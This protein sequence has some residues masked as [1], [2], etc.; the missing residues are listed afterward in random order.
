MDHPA[1]HGAEEGHPGLCE[2]DE[3]NAEC[4]LVSLLCVCDEKV[5]YYAEYAENDAAE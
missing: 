3:E 2:E 4:Y 1:L 5:S